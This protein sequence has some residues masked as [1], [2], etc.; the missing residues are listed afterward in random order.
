MALNLA[1]SYAQRL[2]WITSTL[3]AS[4]ISRPRP[5]RDLHRRSGEA[6]TTSETLWGR[7]LPTPLC[8]CFAFEAR[9]SHD[10]LTQPHNGGGEVEAQETGLNPG[11]VC[12]SGVAPS[13]VAPSCAG[14]HSVDPRPIDSAKALALFAHMAWPSYKADYERRSRPYATRSSLAM[15]K[16]WCHFWP[17]FPL[18][19]RQGMENWPILFRE[20]FSNEFNTKRKIQCSIQPTTN[21]DS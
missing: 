7:H 15:C 9:E 5:D 1:G 12:P 18:R 8:C 2:R 13:G 11:G 20:I 4:R 3:S 16:E 14:A 17:H 21:P 10:Q 6:P 19:C